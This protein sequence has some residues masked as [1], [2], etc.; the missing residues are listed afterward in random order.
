MAACQEVEMNTRY[1][2]ELIDRPS[3]LQPRARFILNIEHL[4]EASI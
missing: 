3:L 1:Q 4:G 2:E